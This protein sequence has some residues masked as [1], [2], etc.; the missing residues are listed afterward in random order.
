MYH[1]C[2]R[3]NY[4]FYFIDEDTQNREVK[5]SDQGDTAKK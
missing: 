4:D 5:Y 1:F 2:S 3:Y